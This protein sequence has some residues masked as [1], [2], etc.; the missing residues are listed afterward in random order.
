MRVRDGPAAVRGEAPPPNATGAGREGGEGGSPESEDLPAPHNQTP[1]GRRIQVLRR[2]ALVAARGGA[3]R[4]AR[5]RRGGRRL[6]PTAFPVTIIA[7]NGKVTVKKQ[8]APHR[9][10]VADGDRV[11]LRDRRRQAGRRGRR[12]VR[13]PEGRAEDVALRLHAERRGHRRVP[14]RPRRHRVRPEGPRRR[15]RA[16]RDHRRPPRRREDVRGRVSADRPARPRHRA[17]RRGAT[18]SSGA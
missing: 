13:L 3:R 4:A 16:A 17:R 5:R 6:A 2:S 14:A 7:S 15:A 12:P 1:R 8:A 9:L 18:G 10:A 11:A